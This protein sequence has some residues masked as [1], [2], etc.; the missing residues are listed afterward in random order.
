MDPRDGCPPDGCPWGGCPLDG[1]PWVAVLRTAASGWLPSGRL[2]RDRCHLDDCSGM[3]ALRTVIPRWLPFGWLP[4][5]WFALRVTPG[6]LASRRLASRWLPGMVAGMPLWAGC[7]GMGAMG[8]V[9]WML[10]AGCRRD[11]CGGSCRCPLGDPWAT[12]GPSWSPP[13]LPVLLPAPPGSPGRI[14]VSLGGCS[15]PAGPGRVWLCRGGV[16]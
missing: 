8:W 4:R 10:W 2:A 6:R 1:C 9:Q 12:L 5:G 14:C 7:R 13:T 15:G 11:G 3:A 16:P